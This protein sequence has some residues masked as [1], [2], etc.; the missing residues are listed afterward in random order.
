MAR[1]VALERRAHGLIARIPQ[2]RDNLSIEQSEVGD[3][4]PSVAAFDGDMRLRDRDA[5]PLQP[6]F[7]ES[8]R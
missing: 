3:D 6:D 5:W 1:K 4:R 8:D 2:L 7:A